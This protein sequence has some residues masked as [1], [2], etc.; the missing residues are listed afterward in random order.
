MRPVVLLSFGPHAQ[1]RGGRSAA[2]LGHLVEQRAQLAASVH[3]G[4]EGGEEERLEVLEPR[5]ALPS[6]VST[7]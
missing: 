1:G 5:L 4:G 6:F 3:V 7:Q 2:G